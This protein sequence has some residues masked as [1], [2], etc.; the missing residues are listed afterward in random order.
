MHDSPFDG[1]QRLVPPSFIALFQRPGS[2]KLREP[3]E[4]VAA[5]HELCEDMAQ[6]L[7]ET[8]QTKRFELGVSEEVVLER[9]HR[10]LLAEG[11]VLAADEAQW[12]VCRLAELLDWPMP[13]PPDRAPG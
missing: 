9:M 2:P 12:V 5:R 4:V 3:R 13:A 8:A 11:G 10:G 6:M 1:D 7:T